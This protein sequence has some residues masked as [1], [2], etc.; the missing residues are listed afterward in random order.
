MPAKSEKQRRY[1]NWKFGHQWVKQHHFDNKGKL[2]QYVNKDENYDSFKEWLNEVHPLVQPS[3]SKIQRNSVR[4]KT[5]YTA[6]F[7]GGADSKAPE[8]VI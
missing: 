4:K 2:P 6:D 7:Q 1:L 8:N 5:T 3:F